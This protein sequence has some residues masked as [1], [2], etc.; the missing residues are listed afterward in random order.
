MLTLYAIKEIVTGV[1]MKILYKD[2]FFFLISAQE[3]DC[4]TC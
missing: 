4:G 1:K 3:M 2:N